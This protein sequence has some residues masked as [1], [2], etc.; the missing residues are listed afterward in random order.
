MGTLLRPFVTS[1]VLFW[2]VLPTA[3]RSVGNA[4]AVYDLI[5]RV[6]QTPSSSSKHPR[7]FRLQLVAPQ[8]EE[9]ATNNVDDVDGH[10]LYFQI[11]D[12]TGESTELDLILVTA[13]TASELS[14]GVG[15][16]LRHYCN[17]TIGWPRG[18]GSRIVIP[19]EWP[20]IGSNAAVRRKRQVP[21]SYFMVRI[22]S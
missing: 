11:E 21:W 13:T 12:I 9:S 19:K 8:E 5:R 17:M 16:Y 2:T 4:S 15:W 7:P 3:G 20:K 22:I 14:A 6:L 10:D 1:L 18:G